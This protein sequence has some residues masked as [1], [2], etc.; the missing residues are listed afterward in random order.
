VPTTGR[1][2][3]VATNGSDSSN[4]SATS[5]WRTLQHAADT[6]QAGDTVIVHAGTYA[7]FIVGWDTPTAG[8][9]SAPITFR[10]DPGT[11]INARNVHTP[12]GIDLEPGCD[13][14]VIDGFTLLGG[15][16]IAAYPTRG[17]GIKVTGNND[18][19]TNNTVTNID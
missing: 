10:A 14:W 5:P 12:T 19:V 2:F 18:V 7:G 9:A 15:G 1:T 3:Y 16:T 8:T 17:S 6:V 11:V 13:Y 4:G